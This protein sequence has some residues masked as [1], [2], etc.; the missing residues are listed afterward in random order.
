MTETDVD[1]ARDA[2][3][4]AQS[5][6]V[7]RRGRSAL[8]RF[9]T[10]LEG[11]AAAS[12]TA[13]DEGRRIRVRALIGAASATVEVDGDVDRAQELLREARDAAQGATDEA[14]TA[15]VDG[16][17]GLLLLRLGRTT[18]AVADLGR[19]LAATHD[20]RDRAILLLNRGAA[21][22]ELGRLDDASRDLRAAAA[23]AETAGDELHASMALHNLGYATY[24]RGDLPKA[25]AEFDAAARRMP[26]EARTVGYL[27]KAQVLLDAGLLTDADAVLERAAR[28]VRSARMARDLAEIELTRSRALL[29][30]GRYARSVELARS[31][32]RRFARMGSEQWT[33]RSEL[34]VLES[35]FAAQRDG[36]DPSR[37]LV[38]RIAAE[39]RA[40]AER[41]RLSRG[42]SGRVT[43]VEARSLLLAA[44]AELVAGRVEAARGLVAHLPRESSGSPLPVR[45]QLQTI[46]AQV[47]FVEGDRAAGLRAVRRG[48][49]LLAGHR[50]R[51]GAVE[52][53]TAA[54]V[55]GLRLNAVD[56]AAAFAAGRP[57]A[58][59]D[60]LERGRATFA[61]AG[62]V[63][64]PEDAQAAELLAQ[65]RR[66]LSRAKAIP[67]DASPAALVERDDFLRHAR[68]LQAEVRERS[69]LHEGDTE[70]PRPVVAR[71]VNELLARRGD[72]TVVA[73][74]TTFGGR[75]RA[76]RLDGVRATV[77]EL[78]DP[79][80]VAEQV[81]RVRADLHVTANSLIPGT[82]RA[83]A[84]QSLA[85]GL[86]WL[87]DT[88]VRPVA[89]AGDLYVAARE[90]VLG[91]PWSSLPSR[92]GLR[93]AVNSYVARGRP[94]G[95]EGAAHRVLAA[96][97]PGVNHAESEVR[98]VAEVWPGARTLVGEAATAAAVRGMLADH[99]VVHLAAHGVH[100]ADNPMFASV[101][102]ADGPLF[103]HELD[104]LRL[105]RSVVVLSACEVG[106]A[107]PGLGGELLGLTSVLLRLGAR[108]V[109]ASVAPL[110]DEAAAQVMPRLHAALRATDDPEGALAS[111]LREMAEP[112]PLVCFGSVAG[113]AG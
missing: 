11:S 24:L 50:A 35:Q 52:A 15:S 79:D 83:V 65:A 98:A 78:G 69:W 108:A 20:E 39:A 74:Y 67:P 107:T 40:I 37:P 48:F 51:L 85:R 9:R 96:A 60:A 112:V 99:D 84:T 4:R 32:R 2:L 87:D 53:V 100:E 31:A 13:G 104:G 72:G 105:P 92:R 80:E 43:G 54:A 66:S 63:H 58:L 27:D 76:V 77:V 7:N 86:A 73:S 23:H 97:G 21:H 57:A 6:L 3:L 8:R 38:R 25:L 70:A 62:R 75:L 30:L 1:R 88:L 29:G 106:G 5:D 64:P 12:W 111:A 36:Q 41:S 81:R 93:T 102:L 33:T 103:A 56:V 18:D 68:R 59:F 45:V 91:L 10:L 28:L 46:R 110:S 89:A 26:E 42:P 94:L 109:V 90:P 95:T 22:L 113:L 61:G 82:L 101:D 19:G 55:H 34:Q 49:D 47:A 16:Q 17:S 14:L 44:E 71:E